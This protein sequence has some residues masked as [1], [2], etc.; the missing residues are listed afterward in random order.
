MASITRNFLCSRT[1]RPSRFERAVQ[2][3]KGM[4]VKSGLYLDGLPLPNRCNARALARASSRGP[5]EVS[6]RALLSEFVVYASAPDIKR[7]VGRAR[8]GADPGRIRVSE[9][10]VVGA[11]VNVE[12]FRLHG[13]VR[14]NHHLEAGASRPT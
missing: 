9:H 13:P 2:P 8:Q 10:R 7:I 6:L 14:S 11:E 3:L 4:V 12:I 1:S 5:H